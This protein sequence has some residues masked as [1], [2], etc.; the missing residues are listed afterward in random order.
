MA[1]LSFHNSAIVLRTVKELASNRWACQRAIASPSRI[2]PQFDEWD[3]G[4]ER[5]LGAEIGG[6]CWNCDESL[7]SNMVGYFML[8][9]TWSAA[10]AALSVSVV[11][12]V[13]ERGNGAVG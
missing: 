1:S 10:A 11:D 6:V 12:G 2:F 3:P 4:C 9:K 13:A 7:T 5:W 8:P